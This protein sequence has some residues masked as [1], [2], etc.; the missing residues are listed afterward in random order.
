MNEL[1]VRDTPEG[2]TFEVN[3]QTKARCTA[4]VGIYEGKLKMNLAAP[5]IDGWA[6]EELQRFFSQ[7]LG[8]PPASIAVPAGEKSPNKQIV[9]GDRTVEEISFAVNGVLMRLN[10][11]VR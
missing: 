3:L 10:N 7:L 5:P 9:I 1:F 6:N 11:G 2:A 8:V 4:I